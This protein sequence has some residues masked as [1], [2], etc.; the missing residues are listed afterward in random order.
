MQT[1]VLTCENPQAR[2]RSTGRAAAILK[3]GGIVG[4]PTETVYGLGVI[5]G[6]REAESRLREVR[7]RELDKPFTI[8]VAEQKA[9]S[10]FVEFIPAP[11][12][13]LMSRCWPGP[14]TIV[15]EN[16]DGGTVGLR[17]PANEV[18]LEMIRRAGGA[19]VAP[20]A[21]HPGEQGAKTADE[22]LAAFAGRIEAVID[23]GPAEL[24]QPSTVVRLRGST[25]E[26]LRQG[27]LSENRLRRAANVVILFVCS[28]NSCRS[29]IAEAFCRK[30]LADRLGIDPERLEEHSYTVLSG[31]LAGGFA[32]PASGKAIGVMHEMG[33]DISNHLSQT[34]TAEMIKYADHTMVMTPDQMDKVLKLAPGAKGRVTLLDPK[35][36]SVEDPHGGDLE[37]YRRTASL[38]R[39]ALEKRIKEL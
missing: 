36:Q 11:G 24:G 5:A 9:V 2:K 1:E 4:F 35:G 15:F 3:A 17:L 23:G 34:I 6:D 18:A 33:A 38:I 7:G 29:P 20:S 30:M 37:T 22:V 16:P 10:N 8:A 13:R 27:A 25:F 19:V 26:V 12:R 14:L 21:N 39:R 31:G 32:A 28:G